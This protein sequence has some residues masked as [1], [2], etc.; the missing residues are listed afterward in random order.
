MSTPLLTPMNPAA[1]PRFNSGRTSAATSALAP[2]SSDLI[3][4]NSD[5]LGSIQLVSAVADSEI[6]FDRLVA[7]KLAS[8]D[9]AVH[10][11]S[12]WRSGLFRKLDDLLDADEWD[13]TDEIPSVASFKTFLRMI[14][15][16]KVTKRPSLGATS[17]GKIIASWR[18]N[19]D[20]LVVECY[21]NDEVRWV[22]SRHLAGK[23]VSAAGTSPVAFLRPALQ[24]YAPEVWFG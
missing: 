8:A 16:N 21:G 15:H 2:K 20:R 14:V 7:L 11:D 4:W 17:D 9:F 10:L 18:A 13:F 5:Q 6:I 24:P 3:R 23:R 12:A 19:G 1:L 22:A